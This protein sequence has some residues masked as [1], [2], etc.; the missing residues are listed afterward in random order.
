MNWFLYDNGPRHERV[1]W[2]LGVPRAHHG[3]ISLFRFSVFITNSIKVNFEFY[4]KLLFLK[5]FDWS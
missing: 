2:F 1:S 4:T 5:D 3:S